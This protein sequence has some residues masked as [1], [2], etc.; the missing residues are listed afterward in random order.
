MGF[1]FQSISSVS[2]H[3]SNELGFSQT[4]I[5]ALIGFF[6]FPGIVLAFPSGWLGRWLKD[7]V[8]VSA[9][10][11]LL[12][13]GGLIV[14]LYD[15]FILMGIGRTISGLGF[16]LAT[17]YFTK[18]AIDWFQ[19]SELSTA[20]GI[21]IVSF[22]GGVALSQLTHP[23][24]ALN[25][26][27]QW[28]IF[29]TSA[30]CLVAAFAIAILY[31]TSNDKTPENP[32]KS[33]ESYLTKQEWIGTSIAAWSWSFY[34]AGYLIFLSFSV[35]ALEEVG[36]P[37]SEAA[38][39][40]G[41][42]SLLVMIAILSG[43]ILSDR[44]KISRS[45]ILLSSTVGTLSLLT[46]PL[47]YFPVASCLL[48]G[49]IGMASGGIVIALSGQSMAPQ[50]RAYGMGVYQT[51]FFL[52]SAPAPLVGGWLYDITGTAA[53]AMTFG[54]LLFLMSAIF[55]F[56]FLKIN[57]NTQLTQATVKEQE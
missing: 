38:N 25:F 8:I 44:L 33:Q 35:R 24:I 31:Q 20:L 47:G 13:I 41:L 26:S 27:W 28:A 11:L 49:L 14:L 37:S 15:D 40:A 50:R 1:Q 5:G 39:T 52:I 6:I 46:L 43:A 57:S 21:L 19:G 10:L 53:A 34:N 7:K 2:D 23:P 9:G 54:A 4:E 29:T 16:V 48:F 30:F 22:P 42:A 55:Y 56:T 18:M 17:V 36:L 3:L 12:F 51:W 45:V 32:I